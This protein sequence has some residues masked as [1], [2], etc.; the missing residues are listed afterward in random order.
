MEALPKMMLHLVAH[1]CSH[2][3]NTKT[4]YDVEK[5]SLDPNKKFKQTE[6]DETKHFL[7][8]VHLIC[9]QIACKTNTVYLV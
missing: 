7:L 6:A 8:R 2:G 5:L 3:C 9:W 4:F 1:C